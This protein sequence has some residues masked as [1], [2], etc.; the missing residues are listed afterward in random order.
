MDLSPTY[1]SEEKKYAGEEKAVAEEKVSHEE[2]TEPDFSSITVTSTP[3]RKEEIIHGKVEPAVE[4]KE[5]VMP[6]MENLDEKQ[7]PETHQMSTTKTEVLEGPDDSSV[8][9]TTTETRSFTTSDDGTVQE[10]IVVHKQ[11]TATLDDDD[12]GKKKAEE[13]KSAMLQKL[14]EELGKLDEELE[15]K[16]KKR[17]TD[18]PEGKLSDDHYV[19][20]PVSGRSDRGQ[21][22]MDAPE[23][24]LSKFEQ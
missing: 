22:L 23:E 8:I 21:G 9:T 14:G 10:H 16:F 2:P 6:K 17:K 15:E 5:A 19:G 3:L 13:D 4:S 7:V 24:M 20:Q 12:A 1:E 11:T 18:K